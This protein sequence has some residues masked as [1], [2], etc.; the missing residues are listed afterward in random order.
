MLALEKNNVALLT[1]PVGHLKTQEVFFALRRRG[2]G[3]CFVIVDFE[4]RPER[5]VLLSHRPAQFVGPPPGDLAAAQGA[6][7][8]D[9]AQWDGVA[10]KIDCALVC[11][12]N[13]LAPD[14]VRSNKIV[15]CHSGI[16]PLVRGLD[17]FKWAIH[18]LQPVGNTLHVIDEEADRGTVLHVEQTPV[19]AHDDLQSFAERHYRFEM[20]L[21]SNFDRYLGEHKTP[22]PHGGERP[23]RRRMNIATEETLPSRFEI[24]KKTFAIPTKRQSASQD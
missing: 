21:L 16:I 18:D 24:F 13:L 6:A 2:I 7:I 22:A 4:K 14:V 1:Y 12:A 9:I 19:F 3:V 20:A 8:F 15:N 11:G 5:E 23:A 10:E 17:A